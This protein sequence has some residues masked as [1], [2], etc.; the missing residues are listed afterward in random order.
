MTGFALRD[1][2]VTLRRRSVLRID[3]L[4]LCAGG[5][6][7]V[8]GPNGAGKSTFLRALAGLLP[9]GGDKRLDGGWPE[10]RRIGFLPQN[11]AVQAALSVA[12]CVLLGRRE[13]LGWRVTPQDRAEVDR[14][15]ARFGLSHLADRRMDALSGGQQQLILLAQ[16]MSRAPRLLI[17][18][19]PTS[20]LDLHH[21]IEALTHLK[22]VAENGVLVIAALH[23]LTLAGRFAD[24]LVLIDEGRLRASGPARHVLSQP[25]LDPVYR[26]ASEYLS[27]RCGNPVI[28]P[29]RRQPA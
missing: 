26:I 16:R 11:F 17:L 1:F 19:E 21:Q 28:V 15:L 18:D 7:G 20:A 2:T 24:R 25:V 10:A 12:E 3:R 22:Q 14:A 8:V 27:D 29:H 13:D 6:I 9:H 4:D 5:F 23:D